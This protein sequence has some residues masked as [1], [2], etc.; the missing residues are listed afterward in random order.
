MKIQI[1]TPTDL[2]ILGAFVFAAIVIACWDDPRWARLIR[3]KLSSTWR[4]T[5]GAWFARR[6]QRIR[7]GA[8]DNHSPGIMV[9]RRDIN[10]GSWT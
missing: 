8:P 7:V 5:I 9:S 4:R 2:A 3:S 1:L 6:R 10:T